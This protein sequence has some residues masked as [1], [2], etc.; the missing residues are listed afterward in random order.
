MAVVTRL[1]TFVDI[2]KPPA[3]GHMSLSARHE[4]VLSDGSRVLLLNDRGWTSSSNSR[5]DLWAST[6]VEEVENDAR[7]VVGPD[8]PFGERSQEEMEA[9]HW[10]YLTDILRE[11][12]VIVDAT[13]LRRMAHDVVIAP[14]VLPR[15]GVRST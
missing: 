9:S 12:G 1:V 14:R 7:A 5:L 13:I 6:S 10:S 3:P 8:E 4:A 15:L 11:H 2:Q